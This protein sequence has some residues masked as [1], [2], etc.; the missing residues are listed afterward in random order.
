MYKVFFN[1]KVVL[2]TE[3]YDLDRI[4][5]G[6]LFLFYDDFEELDFVINLLEGSPLLQ[7]LIIETDD[8]E[9][10]WSD[11]RAHFQEIDAAG[12]LVLNDQSEVLLIHRNNLW[13]LPKGKREN[14]ESTKA[15]ALREVQEECGIDDLIVKDKFLITYHTYR[16]K[17]FRILKSTH[18]YLMKSAQKKFIPQTEEGIDEVKWVGLEQLDWNSYPTYASIQLL[19]DEFQKTEME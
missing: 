17:G 16:I 7:T 14:E 9:I 18:W 4:T 2:L 8:I 19:L 10:L 12:G 11:F 5:C 1:N 6:E 15:C 13:D 3:N